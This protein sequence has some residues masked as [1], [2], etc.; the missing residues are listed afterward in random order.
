MGIDKC[1]FSDLCRDTHGS[2]TCGCPA[3]YF[4]ATDS[5]FNCSDIDE[6]ELGYKFICSHGCRN[7]QGTYE[8]TCPTGYYLQSLW[9]CLDVNECLTGLH[10][11]ELHTWARCRNTEGS[12]TCVCPPGYRIDDVGRS[13]IGQPAKLNLYEVYPSCALMD[14][15]DILCRY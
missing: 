1:Q 11:C 7:L 15:C 6:C 12:Y 10:S 8:C 5:R 2:Y 3:G 4:V 9:I 13:C 14:N